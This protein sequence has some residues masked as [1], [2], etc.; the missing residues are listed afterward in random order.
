MDE[1]KVIRLSKFL[2]LVLRHQP[3]KIGISLDE[4]GWTIVNELL[5]KMKAAGFDID[6]SILQ[7]VVAINNKKRF[8]FSEDGTKIRASQ[9]HSIPVD[10]EYAE[11][12]PPA[13]LYHGTAAKNVSSILQQGLQKKSRHH[14]HL[15]A[16]KETAYLVGQRHGRP[17]I[18]EVS[19]DRMH[20]EG[21]VFYRSANNVWL[22]EKVQT[23][24]LRLL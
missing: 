2:S 11:A 16:D 22:T 21:Q 5:Q 12:V 20:K 13:V 6:Q 7:H 4:Q 3:E 23:N 15:S 10:L 1:K 19:A 14:V 8:A 24:Y 18:F 17:V 9:G